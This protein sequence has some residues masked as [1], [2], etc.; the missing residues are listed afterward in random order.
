MRHWCDSNAYITIEIANFPSKSSSCACE[1]L[2]LHDKILGMEY[3]SQKHEMVYGTF[4]WYGMFE[5][6]NLMATNILMISNTSHMLYYIY[7]SLP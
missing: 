6:D 7:H 5:C 4:L 1:T 2:E 3:N